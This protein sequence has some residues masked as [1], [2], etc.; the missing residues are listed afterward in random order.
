VAA[1]TS[2]HGPANAKMASTM[3]AGTIRYADYAG[4]NKVAARLWWMWA[5]STSPH[6][7]SGG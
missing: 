7:E 4:L 6:G 3:M 1:H 5:F 2:L